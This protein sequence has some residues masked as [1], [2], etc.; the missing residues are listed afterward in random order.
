[1]SPST[2]REKFRL[3]YGQSVFDYLRECRLALAHSQL[4]EG[5]SVQQVAAQVGYRHATNFSTA[6]RQRYGIAPR[7]VR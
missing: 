5:L 4:R 7:E 6:F 3:A 2:L 1:M